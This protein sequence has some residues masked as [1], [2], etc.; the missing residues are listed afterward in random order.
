[1]TTI[2]VTESAIGV[3]LITQEAD[4]TLDALEQL[5]VGP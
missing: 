2:G 3:L 1:M 4:A 5:I